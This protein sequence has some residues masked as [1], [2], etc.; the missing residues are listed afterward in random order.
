M[1]V[2]LGAAVQIRMVA[3]VKNGINSMGAP[4]LRGWRTFTEDG[5]VEAIRLAEDD[6]NVAYRARES[7]Y[8]SKDE[9]IQKKEELG[10]E[11]LR[12]QKDLQFCIMSIRALIRLGF[13]P[14]L[15]E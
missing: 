10:L 5:I 2:E 14:P 15:F 7:Q 13:D 6:S 1:N 9:V 8:K 3:Q 12:K 4:R 11:V